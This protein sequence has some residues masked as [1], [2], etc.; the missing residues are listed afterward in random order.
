MQPANL[1]NRDHPTAVRRLDIACNRRVSIQGQMCPR[2]VIVV[3]VVSEDASEVAIVE[4]DAVIKAL[5]AD[6]SDQAFNIRALP[7]RAVCSHHLLDAHVLDAL[8]KVRP[9]DA[10]AISNH[11]ARRRVIGKRLDNLLSRPLARR[12]RGHVEVHD[13]SS[14]MTKNDKDEQNA[15]RRRWNDKE[16]DGDDVLDVVIEKRSPSL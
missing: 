1:W 8:L 14:M 9:V 2:L 11:E 16:V 10:V 4:N 15:E 3:E 7:R 13:T 6:G 5:P 12:M